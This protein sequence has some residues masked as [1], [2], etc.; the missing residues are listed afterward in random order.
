MDLRRLR[1]FL[2][3]AEELNF[4]RAAMRVPMAQSSLSEQIAKLEA[5]LGTSL[6]VR[7]PRSCELTAAGRQ[8]VELGPDLLAEA[9]AVAATVKPSPGPGPEALMSR[10]QYDAVL[11]VVEDVAGA[12][13]PA[14][15]AD[16]LFGS[17]SSRFGYGNL[18]VGYLMADGTTGGLFSDHPPDLFDWWLENEMAEDPLESPEAV[19]DE[20]RDGVCSLSRLPAE[21]GGGEVAGQMRRRLHAE[22]IANIHLLDGGNYVGFQVNVDH[23]FDASEY[24]AL[25]R[26]GRALQSAIR[27]S[28]PSQR[29][30]AH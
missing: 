28:E 29:R 27:F 30:P 23:T 21:L 20:Q 14:D 1:Y 22:D 11:G 17:V 26:L 3:L 12:T 4:Q 2:V 13:S 5:E 8:L 19:R 18:G 15:L 24:A 7:R 25:G 9:A 6:L 16:R 10:R